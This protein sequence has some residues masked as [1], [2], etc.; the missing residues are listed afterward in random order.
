MCLQGVSDRSDGCLQG[1]P[2]RTDEYIKGASDRS[3]WCLQGASD[4]TDEC[5]QGISYRTT[6]HCRVCSRADYCFQGISYR[7]LLGVSAW[8][9]GCLI[10]HHNK[11]CSVYKVSAKRVACLRLVKENNYIPAFTPLMNRPAI[12][13]S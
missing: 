3:D 1:A 5:L 9:I 7:C 11:L 2:D 4:R 10:I 12:S 6:E 8:T 13:I